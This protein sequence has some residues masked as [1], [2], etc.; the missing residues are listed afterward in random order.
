LCRRETVKRIGYAAVGIFEDDLGLVDIMPLHE[1]ETELEEDRH[2][3]G[4]FDA[5]G[6]GLDIAVLRTFDDRRN[7]TLHGL[8]GD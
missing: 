3:I 1:I 8:V 2:C 4:V 7:S 5:F 6:D